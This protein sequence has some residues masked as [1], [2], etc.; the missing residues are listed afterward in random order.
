M[1]KGIKQSL[2]ISGI[3]SGCLAIGV[4]TTLGSFGTINQAR[5]GSYSL[6]LNS[7]KAPSSLTDS[8]QDNLTATV[9]T[10]DGNSISLCF[11]Y[12]KASSGNFVQ[13]ANRGYLYNFGSE[14]GRFTGITGITATFSGNLTIRTSSAELQN[15]GAF[16]GSSTTLTSGN[17]YIVSSG[18]Y[19]QLQAGDSGATISTLKIDYSC[20]GSP[21]TIPS[22][23]TYN[24]E[25]YESYTAD[26]VGYDSYNGGHAKTATSNLR[27]EYYARFKGDNNADPLNG[28]GWNLMGSGD[29]ITFK[30]NK[31]RSSSKCA[32][33]KVNS[34]NNFSY[35]QTKA[36]RKIPSVIGKGNRLSMWIHG[37]YTSIDASTA[38]TT[39]VTV[40]IMALYHNNFS[41]NGTNAA[42]SVDYV[43][44]AGSDWTEYTL[45]LDPS[46]NYY[47]Y[48]IYI[49]KSSATVYVPVDDI[50]IKTIS[51]T[52]TA[53]DGV[54]HATPT[55]EYKTLFN[56]TTFTVPAVIAISAKKG[57]AGVQFSNQDAV[58]TGYTYNSST[59]KITI[60]TSGSYSYSGITATYGTISGTYDPTNDR[61]T[62]LGLDG[63][64]KS[65]VKNNNNITFNILPS[66]QVWSCE[67]T[68]IMN[69]M[70]TRKYKDGGGNWNYD[71]GNMDRTA[72]D[73][74]NFRSG[75]SGLSPR[76]YSSN[77]YL[78]R[79]TTG[80]SIS[81]VSNFG[82][83]V[84]NPSSTEITM[85]FYVFKTENY[86]N[87]TTAADC[88]CFK[89]GK[90]FAQGWTFFAIGF[91]N[92]SQCPA[93]STITNFALLF[94]ASATRVT[95]DDICLFS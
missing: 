90:T 20:D 13:L 16:L 21:T 12:A 65:Y 1:K 86:D 67:N 9:T 31:G 89:S 69:N 40:K 8:Y 94:H 17:T 92:D 46:K 38:T 63:S 91:R 93:N 28:S 88:Y 54:Y 56:T 39:D 33:F 10:N 84:Y 34:G 44:R 43:I 60:T 5:A 24:V 49:L 52:K 47:S 45:V 53:P 87:L 70:W 62:G 36:L 29:Y 30:S 6:I 4:A 51:T 71:P 7:S 73:N 81:N 41:Y 74:T 59:K 11:V 95:V 2:F 75:N 35:F 80:F 55:I 83:W 79:L 26:G 48:G 23:A 25:D 57:A 82:L 19:F 85:N 64:V 50:T 72:L 58:V 68:N 18:R 78:V 27:S 22:G 14:S 76:P 42:D 61:I 37:G 3:L 66:S 77:P 32:L 15:G